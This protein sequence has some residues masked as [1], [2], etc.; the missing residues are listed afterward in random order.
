MVTLFICDPI[1]PEGRSTSVDIYMADF[2]F[3]VV[4]F[5][6]TYQRVV[7]ST[8]IGVLLLSLTNL[9]IADDT[10][11]FDIVEQSAEVSLNEFALQAEVSLLF[12]AEEVRGV[13]TRRLHGEFAV[14]AALTRLLAGTRLQGRINEW[15]VL[16]VTPMAEVAVS[17]TRQSTGKDTMHTKKSSIF[18]RIGN[19]IA[20]AIFA[21]SGAAV[22]AAEDAGSDTSGV[23]EEIIVTATYRDT[24]LMDTPIA[25]SAVTAEDIQVKGIED[26]QTLYQS[27]PGLSYRTGTQTLNFLSVRG[28]TPPAGGGSSVGVYLDNIPMSD[29]N[30]G[31][32]SQ[33][34]ASLFDMERVEVLKGPQGT[35]YGE[36]NMGGS[37]RYITN[38]VNPNEFEMSAQAGMEAISASDDLSYRADVMINVPLIQDTLGLRA[39]IYKRDRAG[40]LDQVAPANRKDVDTFEE[41]GYRVKLAWYAT[42]DLEISGMYN[43]IDGEYNGPGIA[44]HCFTESTPFD[45]GGQVP[46]YDLP[47]TTCAGQTDQFRRDPYVTHLAHETFTNGGFDDN[48]MMNLSIQWE[49]PFATF[50]ASTSSFDRQTAY[51]EET[52]PRGTAPFIGIVNF[53]SCFGFLPVCGPNTLATG[54]LGGAFY[55]ETDSTVQELRLVSNNTDS[56][57]QWTVGAYFKDDESQSARH[58]ECYNGGSPV[59][60]TIETHCYLQWG[61]FPDV[62]I[63]NQALIV[64]FLNGLVAG[65]AKFNDF[66]E[67]SVYGEVSYRI[68]DQWEITAGLRSANV[69]FDG[70]VAAGLDDTRTNPVSD[71]SVDTSEVSPKVTLTWRPLPDTMIYGT[72]SQG[73]RPGMVNSN[74]TGRLA[75]LDAVRAGNAIAEAHYQRLVDNQT[76]DGDTLRNYELGIKS[77]ILDGQV[78]YTAS[79]YRI[80]WEDTIVAVQ[81]TIDDVV[82]VT[83]FQYLFNFNAGGATSEGI[84]IE[85]RAQ[86]TEALSLNVGGDFNWEAKVSSGGAAIPPG[87]RLANAPEHSAYVALAYD[88]QL[89]GYDATARLDGYKVAESWNTANNEQPA[90]AYQTV[91]ARLTLR[92][93]DRWQIAGYFRNLFDEE[94]IFELNQVGY[95]FG[96]PR[97]FG[98]QFN[99]DLN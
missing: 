31:G 81:D 74:L 34:L 8:L 94:I 64:Q 27:I 13:T 98:I 70:I 32:K 54:G 9:S 52:S 35:L 7:R 65:N 55:R 83:P 1:H 44:F 10:R 78:S 63:A 23:V 47:G 22:T 6:Q 69:T 84:E 45:P 18:G 56:R 42:E 96:R 90:P 39:V 14:E 79:L 19:A 40:V 71:L 33:P 49:L 57:W 67:E 2:L 66:G 25:I 4:S 53:A 89:F 46:P 29:N 61:F 17:A 3:C 36:G 88:F 51:N 91:D 85:V 82:G 95:R 50:T 30:S 72:V 73:F 41:N 16:T 60:Q 58:A 38:K 87:N 21:T 5:V 92:G 37:I 97:T 75:E 24:R 86:L 62:P 68:N 77:T 76:V 99:Y 48:E 43:R 93:G 28:I 20:T 12:V 59:Y 26:I 80:D 15:G 11:Q